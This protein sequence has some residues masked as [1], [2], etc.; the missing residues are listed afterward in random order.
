MSDNMKTLK[1]TL[2]YEFEFL[3]HLLRG[4]RTFLESDPLM[5]ALF[6]TINVSYLALDSLA[7]LVYCV[8]DIYICIFSK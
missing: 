1:K 4:W 6:R 7:V 2:F 3:T 5:Q 8:Q